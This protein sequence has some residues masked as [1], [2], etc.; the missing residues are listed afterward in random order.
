MPV[1]TSGT[2]LA[3]LLFFSKSTPSLTTIVGVD[4]LNLINITIN[5]S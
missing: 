5:T 3:L 1:F 4:L 2:L